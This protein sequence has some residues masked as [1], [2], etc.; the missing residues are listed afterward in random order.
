MHL[1]PDTLEAM[2]K[3]AKL[4]RHQD[5][6]QVS[7]GVSLKDINSHADDSRWS[8]P[9]ETHHSPDFTYSQLDRPE[10]MDPILTEDGEPMLNPGTTSL[11]FA[12]RSFALTAGSVAELLTQ[13]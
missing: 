10:P 13:V 6:D 3:T 5:N 8:S 11:L 12:R 4:H 7:G 1:T 2:L 9:V